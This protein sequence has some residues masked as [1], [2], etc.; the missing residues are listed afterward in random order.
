MR[1]FV[2]TAAAARVLLHEAR[3]NELTL[4]PNVSWQSS[5]SVENAVTER[6]ENI[7]FAESIFSTIIINDSPLSVGDPNVK[8]LKLELK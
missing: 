4:P 8:L 5:D 7:V 6:T 3:R 2:A 1:N